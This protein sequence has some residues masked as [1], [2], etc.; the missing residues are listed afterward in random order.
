[1]KSY[2]TSLGL[3]KSVQ[4]GNSTCEAPVAGGL[5]EITKNS[6]ALWLEDKK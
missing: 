6:K 4:T 1:M 2:Q 3:R 5:L